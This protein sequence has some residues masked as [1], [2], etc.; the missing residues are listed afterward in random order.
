[1]RTMQEIDDNIKLVHDELTRLRTEKEALG[2]AA[3]NK[4]LQEIFNQ[5]QAG[6]FIRVGG[7]SFS[8]FI[9]VKTIKLNKK[10]DKWNGN[11]E[12]IPVADP[13]YPNF[14][15]A[16]HDDGYVSFNIFSG[17]SGVFIQINS[18]DVVT[19]WKIITEIEYLKILDQALILNLDAQR[20]LKF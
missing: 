20:I 2:Y 18:E 7:E 15:L 12:L 17:D 9:C 11:I 6:M 1:M 19:E 16:A 13:R 8:Q 5:I 4:V 14:S 3:Q 10:E